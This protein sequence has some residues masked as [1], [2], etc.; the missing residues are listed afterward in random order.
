[1]ESN[2]K[3]HYV[4]MRELD[5]KQLH[6]ELDPVS[7]HLRDKETMST[8]LPNGKSVDGPMKDRQ[9][10]RIQSYQEYWHSWKQFHPETGA[11]DERK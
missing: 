4:L 2:R 6:F 11:Y 5:G 9:L 3:T 10:T 8:W 7:G 1:M